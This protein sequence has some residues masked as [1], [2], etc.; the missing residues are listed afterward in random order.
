V[1]AT[2]TEK[3]NKTLHAIPKEYLRNFPIDVVRETKD[4]I[5]IGDPIISA[6]FD[7]AAGKHMIELSEKELA[8]RFLGPEGAILEIQRASQ[9]GF[10]AE[11]E[12]KRLTEKLH[13]IRAEIDSKFQDPWMRESILFDASRIQDFLDKRHYLSF[14]NWL[15]NG[16]KP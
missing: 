8:Q 6:A 11:I 10:L 5:K 13:K 2:V 15:N 9:A 7:V 1:V 4:W 16:K 12:A 14:A 3:A